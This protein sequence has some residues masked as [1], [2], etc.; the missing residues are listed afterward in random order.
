MMGKSNVWMWIILL[1]KVADNPDD[2]ILSEV[3]RGGLYGGLAFDKV[4]YNSIS[5][6]PGSTHLY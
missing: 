5:G 6:Y 3:K 1:M 4:F 2:A